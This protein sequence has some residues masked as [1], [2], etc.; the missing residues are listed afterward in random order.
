MYTNDNHFNACE[1]AAKLLNVCLNIR[2]LEHLRLAMNCVARD[3]F[4]D[5]LMFDSHRSIFLFFLT[6]AACSCAVGLD[7]CTLCNTVCRK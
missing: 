5:Y 3:I 2:Y 4:F 1:T 6:L 7:T